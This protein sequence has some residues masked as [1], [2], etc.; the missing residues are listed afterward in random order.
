MQ[1]L[2]I[3]KFQ[4]PFPSVFIDGVCLDKELC[5]A[6]NECPTITDID[7]CVK[8]RGM[9]PLALRHAQKLLDGIESF[10][11]GVRFFNFV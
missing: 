7:L 10:E 11:L 4:R 3:E 5:S 1:P 8:H 6:R 2:K 9:N